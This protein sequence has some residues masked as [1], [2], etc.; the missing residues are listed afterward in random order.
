MQLGG[1]F[2]M[3][4]PMF[5]LLK[6]RF[7]Q[8]QLDDMLSILHFTGNSTSLESFYNELLYFKDAISRVPVEYKFFDE[9]PFSSLGLQV[10][11]KEGVTGDGSNETYT[12]IVNEIV[13]LVVKRVL[14]SYQKGEKYFSLE[15][16]VNEP[17]KSLYDSVESFLKDKVEVSVNTSKLAKE[18]IKDIPVVDT[19]SSSDERVI[20]AWIDNLDITKQVSRTFKGSKGIINLTEDEYVFLNALIDNS[21]DIDDVIERFVPSSGDKYKVFDVPF[22]SLISRR[23]TS[24]YRIVSNKI[25]AGT[26]KSNSI[27]TNAVSSVRTEIKK[28]K[29]YFKDLVKVEEQFNDS[30]ISNEKFLEILGERP[31]DSFNFFAE[32][33]ENGIIDSSNLTE[34][35]IKIILDLFDIVSLS[36]IDGINS[37]LGTNF[38]KV[39]FNRLVSIMNEL[40]LYGVNDKTL[41]LFKDS[42]Q[43]IVIYS[44]LELTRTKE[45]I[46]EYDKVVRDIDNLLET[47]IPLGSALV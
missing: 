1:C 16:F 3:T 23:P 27:F 25:D 47:L 45:A 4:A 2:G 7:S 44:S 22:T 32:L 19:L 5:I 26:D 34:S 33:S 21:T 14:R 31:D 43:S 38:N 35:D 41:E 36:S 6:S 28:F 15:K 9:K 13:N 29:Q 12:M 10:S 24:L 30:F 11:L 17:V 40:E 42:F 37:I 18:F 20:S 8:K 39:S 46:D